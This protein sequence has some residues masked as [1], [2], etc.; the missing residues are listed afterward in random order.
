MLDAAAMPVQKLKGL[1]D[2]S[3]RWSAMAVV[4]T[5]EQLPKSVSYLTFISEACNPKAAKESCRFHQHPINP[6]V[7]ARLLNATKLFVFVCYICSADF[8]RN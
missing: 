5:T 8:L 3:W 6:H 4:E 2:Y 1:L 7:I